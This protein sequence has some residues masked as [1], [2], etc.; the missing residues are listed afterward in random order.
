MLSVS[1]AYGHA[2][3]GAI[4]FITPHAFSKRME[5]KASNAEQQAPHFIQIFGG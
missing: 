3:I 1:G 5:S 2:K 4:L